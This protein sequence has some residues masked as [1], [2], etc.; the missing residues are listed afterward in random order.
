M[1]RGERGDEWGEHPRKQIEQFTKIHAST[2]RRHAILR[3]EPRRAGSEQIR[4]ER[5]TGGTSDRQQ[6]TK[7][8]TQEGRKKPRKAEERH[9]IGDVCR[10]TRFALLPVFFLPSWVPNSIP[11]YRELL[12]TI[13][14]E[15]AMVSRANRLAHTEIVL[16]STGGCRTAVRWLIWFSQAGPWSRLFPSRG[17]C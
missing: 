13:V 12:R 3:R 8:G 11:P 15:N 9:K 5:A 7:L 14:P 10:L 4:L 2:F 1:E 16:A 6:R 17:V